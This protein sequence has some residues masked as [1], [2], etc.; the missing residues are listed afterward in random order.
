LRTAWEGTEPTSQDE[1][2][3]VS[4]SLWVILAV[5]IVVIALLAR[6]CS[7]SSSKTTPLT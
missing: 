5:A 1:E 3:L 2:V 6:G 7:W 4:T